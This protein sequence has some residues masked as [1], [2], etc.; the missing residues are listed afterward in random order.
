MNTSTPNV[1]REQAAAVASLL[2]SIRPA[3]DELATAHSV[4][5][6]SKVHADLADLVHGCIRTAQDSAARTPAALT[7]A[8]SPHWRITVRTTESPA[9]RKARVQAQIDARAEPPLP[10]SAAKEAAKAEARR[11]LAAALLRQQ[12]TNPTEGDS[13]CMTR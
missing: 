4:A 9:E 3:W 5:E 7:F 12:H 13:R 6:A 11:I 1:S 2:R 8:D 10:T